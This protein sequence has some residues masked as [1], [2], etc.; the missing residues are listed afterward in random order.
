[1]DALFLVIVF[2]IASLC[3]VAIMAVACVDPEGSDAHQALD[4]HESHPFAG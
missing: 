2:V 3:G 4:A 1:M